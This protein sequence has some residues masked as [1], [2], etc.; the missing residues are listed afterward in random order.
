VGV[1]SGIPGYFLSSAVLGDN[2]EFLGAMVVKLE[3]PELEREWS[4]GSDTLLVSDARDH[5]HRQPAR[6]ALSLVTAAGQPRHGR[7]KAYPPV[8]QTAAGPADASVAASLRRQ[9]RLAP[10]RRPGRNGGLPVGICR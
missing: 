4:Q 5:L 7:I 2:A 9:Q 6:L 8:R 3:F 1:T 10:G